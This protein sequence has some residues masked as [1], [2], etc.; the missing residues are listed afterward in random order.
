MKCAIF[1]LQ[2][3]SCVI[4]IKESTDIHIL[5]FL[6]LTTHL[7]HTYRV[8]ASPPR[9]MYTSLFQTFKY[10]GH[11]KAR[12]ESILR[13]YSVDCSKMYEG[14]RVRKD[15]CQIVLS[16]KQIFGGQRHSIGTG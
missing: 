8:V 7:Y 12:I 2:K 9:H 14:A 15:V 10:L 5:T 1:H 6:T 16:E 3:T 11:N 13:L 4:H